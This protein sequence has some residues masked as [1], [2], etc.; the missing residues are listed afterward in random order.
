M[1]YSFSNMRQINFRVLSLESVTK[2]D[3]WAFFALYDPRDTPTE[4]SPAVPYLSPYTQSGS[5]LLDG[6]KKGTVCR[7]IS[8]LMRY[9]LWI[10]PG[11]EY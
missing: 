8:A 1:V 3:Y 10:A 11:I 6:D 5:Q 2:R 4:A 7:Q 9:I